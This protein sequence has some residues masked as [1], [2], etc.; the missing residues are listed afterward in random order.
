MKTDAVKTRETAHSLPDLTGRKAVVVGP[1]VR[2]FHLDA[3]LFIENEGLVQVA[4]A[5]GLR[6]ALERL[7]DHPDEASEMGE[8]AYR[9]LLAQQGACERIADAISRL[10]LSDGDR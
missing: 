8:R 9:T 1:D 4:D 3:E 6:S 7:L 5:A 10:E 2:N